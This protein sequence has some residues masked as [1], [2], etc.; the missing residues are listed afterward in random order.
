MT[1]TKSK[2]RVS[3]LVATL[4]ALMRA[5]TLHEVR[6]TLDYCTDRFLVHPSEDVLEK[7]YRTV[8]KAKP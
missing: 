2:K 7:F 5:E 3:S 8:R 4:R 6:A 1:M